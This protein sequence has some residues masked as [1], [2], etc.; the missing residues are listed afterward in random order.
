MAIRTSQVYTILLLKKQA[1]FIF[2]QSKK[3]SSIEEI[4]SQ[5]LTVLHVVLRSIDLYKSIFIV[6]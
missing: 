1:D 4:Y 2:L 6:R 5:S 3:V